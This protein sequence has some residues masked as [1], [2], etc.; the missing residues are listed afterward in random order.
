MLT[1]VVKQNLIQ[2][3]CDLLTTT[4]VHREINRLGNCSSDTDVQGNGM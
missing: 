2:M 1:R 3:V 4:A